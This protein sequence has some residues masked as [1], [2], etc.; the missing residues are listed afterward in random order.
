M[1]HSK[2]KSQ[3]E[4]LKGDTLVEHL[5]TDFEILNQ[6]K[7]IK[8]GLPVITY[9]LSPFRDLNEKK[10]STYMSRWVAR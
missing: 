1:D 6:F 7:V 2:F 8:I 9:V 10:K 4:N 5:N 3:E